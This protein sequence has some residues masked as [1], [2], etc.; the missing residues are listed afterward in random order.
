MSEARTDALT[1]LAD[2]RGLFERLGEEL[3]ARAALA[4]AVIDL[5]RFRQL[6]DA[7]GH[8]AG[9]RILVAL[10]AAAGAARR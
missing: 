10:R 3:R 1:Q 7:F 5:D 9:D 8:E 6:N 2:R 4:V